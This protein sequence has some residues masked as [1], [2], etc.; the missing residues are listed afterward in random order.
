MAPVDSLPSI[1]PPCLRVRVRY[2]HFDNVTTRAQRRAL[3][4]SP[5]Y[6]SVIQVD[7]HKCMVAT[8]RDALLIHVSHSSHLNLGRDQHSVESARPSAWLVGD[9][10]THRLS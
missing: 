2:A 5:R 4:R 1:A 3:A 10:W 9:R 6:F 8:G 7:N